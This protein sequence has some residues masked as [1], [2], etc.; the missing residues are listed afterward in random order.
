M[1]TDEKAAD[2][3]I[4]KPVRQTCSD[5]N[6]CVHVMYARIRLQSLLITAVCSDYTVTHLVLSAANHGGT[7]FT[8][9]LAHI[10]K[11]SLFWSYIESL[12][13]RL[14]CCDNLFS[15]QPLSSGCHKC[16]HSSSSAD[17]RG[18]SCKL[19][20]CVKCRVLTLA[21]YKS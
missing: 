9:K 21:R 15:S 4:S 10:E 11:V 3:S 1:K 12:L 8:K 17:T 2:T 6:M 5:T 13:E 19:M 16:S 14:Q 18:G 20:S 7:T